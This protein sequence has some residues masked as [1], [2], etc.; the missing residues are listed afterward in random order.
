M[1]EVLL[2]RGALVEESD[3]ELWATPIAWAQKMGHSHILQLL[4]GNLG[5]GT[6]VS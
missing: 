4:Q 1:A 5:A 2:K 6:P 3:A